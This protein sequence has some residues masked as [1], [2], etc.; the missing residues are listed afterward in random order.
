M[1]LLDAMRNM[2]E[3]WLH[4]ERYLFAFGF[5]KACCHLLTNVSQINKVLLSIVPRAAIH[6]KV[7]F[8]NHIH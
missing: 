1:D 2:P 4:F 6:L 7:M 5:L 8:L 3:L